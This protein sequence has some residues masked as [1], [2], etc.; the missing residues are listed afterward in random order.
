MEQE[1]T[2]VVME[3]NALAPNW[4]QTIFQSANEIAANTIFRKRLDEIQSQT[5]SE[6][7][8]WEKR[9]ASIQ[10]EFMKELDESSN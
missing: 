5:E 7:E 8:W 3:A 10:A 9:R 6:K 1:L 4:G 2:D